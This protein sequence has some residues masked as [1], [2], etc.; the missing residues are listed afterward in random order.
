MSG[1]AGRGA[2]PAEPPPELLA[3]WRA[4]TPG[5]A[6]RVHLNNAGAALVPSVVERAITEHLARES[7]EGGYEA[8]DAVQEEVAAAYGALARLVGAAPRNIAVVRSATDAFAQALSAFDLGPGD[9]ILTSNDD[10]ISNQLMFLSLARRRGVRVVRAPDAPEGGVDVEAFT[11]LLRTERPRLASLTWI[12]TSGGLIQPA[13]A[14]GAA[15]RAAGV[16]FL[17]DACQ[18]VG[19]LEVDLAALHCDYLAATA[20]K[21]LRGPRGIGFLV[22]SDRAIARGD[23]PLFVDMRGADWVGPD[24][25]ALAEG[26][27][28]F[29]QWESS[30]AL[31]LGLGAAARHALEVGV[32]V[33]AA[34]AHALAAEVRS[35]LAAIPGV[36]ALDRGARLSAIAT[37]AIEGRTGRDVMLALRAQGINASQQGRGDA[38]IPLDRAGAASLLRVSPHYYNTADEIERLTQALTALLA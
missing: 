24:A 20:R 1:A 28:R 22:V 13:E 4:D 16:P 14:V 11:T 29:E 21:F 19:Q 27:R 25:F 23:H 18:A 10:Y 5:C 17:L 8:A 38:L 12:P 30:Y 35:R 31:L 7:R 2:D 9:V 34:R 3:R 6:R 36:R 32:D 33:A 26:A 15:C 37:F